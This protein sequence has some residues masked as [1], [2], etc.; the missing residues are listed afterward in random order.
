MTWYKLEITR[1]NWDVEQIVLNRMKALFRSYLGEKF[2]QIDLY[3]RRP[4]KIGESYPFTM[5]LPP[6][7]TQYCQDLLDTYFTPCERPDS[8]GLSG[9]FGTAP[10]ESFG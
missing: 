9:E 3:A 4:N 2:P 1:E 6:I 10:I 7:A 8:A 5:Y